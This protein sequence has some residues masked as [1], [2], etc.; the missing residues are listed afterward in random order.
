MTGTALVGQIDFFWENAMRTLIVISSILLASTAIAGAA[1]SNGKYCLNERAA[2]D[3][4]NC[5]FTT[6]AQCLASKTAPSDT[7]SPNPRATT[8]S[9]HMKK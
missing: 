8:G 4:A 5:S 6:L 9:G 1:G 3:D 7:C 2:G